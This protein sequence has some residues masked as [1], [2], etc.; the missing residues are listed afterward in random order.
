MTQQP[1]KEIL[2]Y[3]DRFNER[4]R[5]FTGIG[6]LEFARTQELLKRYLPQPP[7]VILDV[8]GGPG[9]Y[10]CWLAKE[11]YEVHLIDP[12]RTHVAQ[13]KQASQNQPEYPVASFTI[14]DARKL[15]FT[16]D[17]ADVI[18]FFGP[19]YHLTDRN[20]RLIALREAYRTLRHDGLLL[21]VAISRFASTLEG[22]LQGLLN[23]P[24]FA[25]IVEGDLCDGQHRNPTENI[26]YFTSAYFH[27]PAELQ[28]E[29]EEAGF[30]Y[31]W[32]IA[33]EGIGGLVQNFEYWENP[34]RKK[35]LLDIL[36][37][38]EKEPSLIGVSA[39]IMAVAKKK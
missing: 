13:V 35:Q 24:Q 16:N 37:K 33:I 2:E 27:R 9:T 6:K 39:H 1:R 34:R 19:L 31:E 29:I 3:Y 36:R 7:A 4:E 15:D 14:G 11:G 26:D 17:Y 5:L 30:L 28:A 18:L 8:G 23:D 25:S 32:S 38:L 10:A 20:D 12:V 22:L 21:A